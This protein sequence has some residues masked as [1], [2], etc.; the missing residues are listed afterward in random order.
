MA[1]TCNPST[2]ELL[3]YFSK[4]HLLTRSIEEETEIGTIQTMEFNSVVQGNELL[5][6]GE[7]R[8]L[9]SPL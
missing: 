9:A 7:R 1:L 3:E 6:H 4:I 8:K 5:M 2:E